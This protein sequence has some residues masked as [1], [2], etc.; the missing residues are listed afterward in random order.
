VDTGVLV[1]DGVRVNGGVA[2]G[3]GDA[4]IRSVSVLEAT[5]DA[6]SDVAGDGLGDTEMEDVGDLESVMYSVVESETDNK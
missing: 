3:T 4:D 6:D 2:V 5:A 1:G